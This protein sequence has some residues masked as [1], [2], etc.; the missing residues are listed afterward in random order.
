M[1]VG[2]HSLQPN[3]QMFAALFERL[4]KSKFRSRFRLGAKERAYYEQKGADEV[5]NQAR[6]FIK[7]RLAPAQPANDGKQTPM[8]NHPVFIAQHATATCC[9]SCLAKWHGIPAGKELI[10]EEIDYVVRVITQWLK[11]ETTISQRTQI[12]LKSK[13]K[14]QKAK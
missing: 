9:R 4:S 6:Q 12:S 13:I 3:D 8:R 14:M 7:A 1:V 5:A 10:E 11:C 2:E